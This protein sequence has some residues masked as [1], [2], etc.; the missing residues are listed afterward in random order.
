[1]NYFDY[2]ARLG[3]DSEHARLW[4]VRM[5]IARRLNCIV[6]TCEEGTD[7]LSAG[8]CERR[9]S[10]ARAMREGRF[11]PSA[12][13]LKRTDPAMFARVQECERRLRRRKGAA[14]LARHCGMGLGLLKPDAGLAALEAH[15][16][17]WYAGRYR[18]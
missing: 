14:H 17:A 11:R 13:N 3:A 18:K 12:A 5:N 6:R 2:C 1:M 10:E 9:I 15:V 8:D 7:T 4:R 16:A